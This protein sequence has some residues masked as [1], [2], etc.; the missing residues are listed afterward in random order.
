MDWP[1]RQAS[2][3]GTHEA[4]YISDPDGNDLELC[5][6]RPWDQW[7][8][9]ERGALHAVSAVCTHMGCIVGWNETDRSWDCPCHG[10]RFALDGEVIH[11]PAVKPLVRA[12]VPAAEQGAETVS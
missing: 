1:I 10:S 8:R 6:D 9:D 11:G 5:W 2:D 12:E 7:A 3:H 4:I